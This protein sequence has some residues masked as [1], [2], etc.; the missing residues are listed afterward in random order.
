MK[1]T[2]LAFAWALLLALAPAR[3][4]AASILWARVDPLADVVLYR[5]GEE[6]RQA[7]SRFQID[8][9]SVNAAKMSVTDALGATHSLMIVYEG[10]GGAMVSDDPASTVAELDFSGLDTQSEG[11]WI[12]VCLGDYDVDDLVVRFELGYVD[13]NAYESFFSESDPSTWADGVFEPLAFA[14]GTVGGLAP[15]VYE[16]S[17]L[18][19]PSATPWTPSVFTAVPEPSVCWTAL[20]GVLLL[21]RRRRAAGPRLAVR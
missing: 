16:Q 19:T 10:Q 2:V 15:Y 20:L 3:A 7:V 17:S 14:E 11:G 1:R 5:D 12:P 6:L 18:S 21:S 13:W 8:G 4:P 9:R